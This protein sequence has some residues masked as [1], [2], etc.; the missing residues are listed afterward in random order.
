MIVKN[1]SHVIENTLKMLTECIDF[2]YWVI[3]DTGSTD[4]T[5]EIIK[6]FFKIKGI[7]GEL[8]EHS[9]R[10]FGT[11]RTY[12]LECAYNKSDYLFIFDADDTIHGDFNIDQSKLIDDM[13]HLKFGNDFIYKRPL[14]INN[15]LKWKFCGVLHEYLICLDTLKTQSLLEGNYHIESGKNG[16]RSHDPDKYKKDAKILEDAYYKEQDYG[17]KH[18]YGF[19]CAQSYMDAKDIHNSIK[20]YKLVVDELTNWNQEKYYSCL[21]IANLSKSIHNDIDI[22]TYLSK[23]GQFDNER[24]EHIKRLMEYFYNKGLHI[25]VNALYIQNKD[26]RNKFSNNLESKL[27]V[28]LDDY[29]YH[30][31]YYNS[32]SSYYSND[33]NNGYECCKKILLSN[34]KCISESNRCNN[35]IL[36][37]TLSNLYF[38]KDQLLNDDDICKEKLKYIFSLLNAY[39][40]TDDNYNIFVEL[41]NILYK[42]LECTLSKYIYYSPDKINNTPITIFL[43]MTT[44]KRFNLFE[45]TVNSIFNQWKDKDLIDYWFCV[46]DNSNDEDRENMK[47]K[48]P[49]FNYYFKNKHEKGHRKS[50]NIIWNKLNELRPKYW[51]HLEDDFLF[52]ETLNYIEKGIEGLK[53]LESH[54]VKQVLFNRCYAE[55]F[56]DYKIKGYIPY[57][58]SEFCIHDYNMNCDNS[59]PNCQYWPHYSFRPSIVDVNTILELG[60]FNSINQFFE[61]DYANKWTINGYKSAFFNKITNVHIGRLTSERNN[62]KKLNAYELNNESQFIGKNDKEVD[63]ITPYIKVI[64][65]KRRI[66]RKNKVIQ[67][68]ND[69]N[70]SLYDY[71]FIDAIDGKE[72]TIKCKQLKLFKGNDFGNRR[73]FIG[74]ALSHY[75]LWLKLL[76]DPILDYYLIM[77]DDFEINKDFNKYINLLKD[78]MKNKEIIFMGYHVFSFNREKVKDV[79]NNNNI[80]INIDDNNESKSTH[81]D[82]RIEKLNKDLFIGGTHCYSINKEGAMKMI[83]YIYENGIKH[84]IDYVMGK[85]NYNI[86]YEVQPQICIADWNENGKDIDTDIQNVY[87]SIEIDNINDKSEIKYDNDNDNDNECREE[88]IISKFVFIKGKDQLNYD[89]FYKKGSILENMKLVIRHSDCIGF[90]TL[91]F[92]KNKLEDLTESRYF[93]NNV[94]GI[95]IRKDVYETFIEERNKTKIEKEIQNQ[96]EMVEMA[97]NEKKIK[98]KL[99]CNWCSS[100]ELCKEWSIMLNNSYIYDNIEITYEDDNVDYYIIINKPFNETDIYIPSKTLIFQMEPWVYDKNKNWGVKTWGEWSTPDENRFL[101]VSNHKKHLNTVQWQIKIPNIISNKKNELLNTKFKRKNK[102]ISIL[103]YKNW[104]IG[105]QKRIDFIKFVDK[106]N[107]SKNIEVYGKKNY[108]NFKNYIGKLKDDKK[109]HHL[110]QYKYCLSVENNS[111]YNYATEKLWE[112][113]LCECLCFYWGCPNI[114]D[115][116]DSRAYVKLDLNNFSE[117][118]NIINKA[119]EEDWWSLRREIILREKERIINEL[120][121]FPRLKKILNDINYTQIL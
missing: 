36:K 104:D 71:E 66:D 83:K 112:P 113:I 89:M 44:C 98:I 16:F 88:N 100:K 58:N 26:Y 73:G 19:Y 17:L 97:I 76:N 79:C 7:S 103:S 50:M 78:E 30:I 70:I 3:S 120:G 32:I 15:R 12:A 37:S 29:K 115:Y 22:I 51:I 48:Y 13:Y 91:G 106:S 96:I 39:I 42:K 57:K 108:H 9:W 33:F 63:N 45:K 82:L 31:E 68:F 5:K 41:W 75:N 40:E 14:L 21:M 60:D 62:K 59:Y 69:N 27:F 77:E 47:M 55:T 111:E 20:W 109:E 34:F 119:I 95:Y 80:N 35:S 8:V 86:C 121:F 43:S 92:F 23:A 52:Y 99:L 74:C 24:F 4:N 117:S 116:I 85:L 25:L 67:L 72:L 93:N 46:D 87:D 1:E 118:L 81:I 2:S 90:N 53:L 94:D 61:M 105:H 110:I 6:D 18:R 84:G 102:I 107:N 11:N 10:D 65:L 101:Y 64:N 114:E 54:N 56:E 28:S 38:Y 49:I